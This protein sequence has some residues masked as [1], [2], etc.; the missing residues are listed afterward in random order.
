M[1][2]SW[3]IHLVGA[4]SLVESCGGI[5]TLAMSSRIETQIGILTWYTQPA[6]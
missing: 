2:G 5:E 1:L 6:F 4:Y 3:R